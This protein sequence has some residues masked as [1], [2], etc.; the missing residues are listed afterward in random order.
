MFGFTHIF[1]YNQSVIFKYFHI[2]PPIMRTALNL[3]RP[4]SCW[5]KPPRS[6]SFHIGK[7]LYLT[8]KRASLTIQAVFA[9]NNQNHNITSSGVI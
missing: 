8:I 7:P 1:Q 4:I 5:N 3:S 6:D 9:L 2:H